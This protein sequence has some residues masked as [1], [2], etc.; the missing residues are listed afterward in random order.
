MHSGTDNLGGWDIDFDMTSRWENLMEWSSRFLFIIQGVQKGCS[1]VTLALVL[2][3]R[4]KEDI[5][6]LLM[7]QIIFQTRSNIKLENTLLFQE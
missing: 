5:A 1:V 4:D 2:K 7:L 3:R 6:L